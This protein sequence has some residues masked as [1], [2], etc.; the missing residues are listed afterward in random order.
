MVGVRHEMVW[1]YAQLR[2]DVHCP[3]LASLSIESS[4]EA[5]GVE[6]PNSLASIWSIDVSATTSVSDVPPRRVPVRKEPDA[7]A[8]T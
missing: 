7:P 2:P 3:A 5:S 6:A 1:V 4:S 8:C